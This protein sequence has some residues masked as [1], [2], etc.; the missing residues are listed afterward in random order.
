MSLL[1]FYFEMQNLE[2]AWL[3]QRE[4]DEAGKACGNTAGSLLS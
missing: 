3:Q 1:Q 4:V 2:W